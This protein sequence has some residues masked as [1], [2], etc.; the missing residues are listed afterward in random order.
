MRN[1]NKIIKNMKYLKSGFNNIKELIGIFIDDENN[2][3]GYDIYIKS[4]DLELAQTATLLQNIEHEQE[5]KRFS[6]F[7]TKETKKQKQVKKN[8]SPLE[9]PKMI[10]TSNDINNENNELEPDK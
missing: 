10:S 1:M 7:N 2:Q 9:P 3:E 6:L 8:Y 4:P 5:E